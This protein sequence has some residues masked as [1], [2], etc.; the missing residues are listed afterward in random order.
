MTNEYKQK[1]QKYT[2]FLIYYKIIVSLSQFYQRT[3]V[4]S[5]THAQHSKLMFIRI[6]YYIIIYCALVLMIELFN[7][8]INLIKL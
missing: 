2:L 1:H 3:I 6:N 8:T 7:S 4:L 5:L